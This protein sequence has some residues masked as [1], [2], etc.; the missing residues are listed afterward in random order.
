MAETMSYSAGPSAS[1]SGARSVVRRHVSDA[2][3]S[4]VPGALSGCTSRGV[5]GE[6]PGSQVAWRLQDFVDVG[7]RNSAFVLAC[8]RK[9]ADTGT[10]GIDGKSPA[11]GTIADGETLARAG[12]GH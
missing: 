8:V 9:I 3:C 7:G 12:A 1:P 10:D 5:F 11:A 6:S 4:T 2:R